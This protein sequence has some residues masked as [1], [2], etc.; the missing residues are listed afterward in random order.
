MQKANLRFGFYIVET[1]MLRLKIR[2]SL[3]KNMLA[4]KVL[5]QLLKHKQ[6]YFYLN[7]AGKCASEL[8]T[9]DIQSR[10]TCD[11]SCRIWGNTW[12]LSF[13]VEENSGNLQLAGFIIM[14]HP[15]DVWL[16][17]LSVFTEPRN[18]QIW[19]HSVHLQSGSSGPHWD[20]WVLWCH[21]CKLY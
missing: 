10:S 8:L 21:Y 18:L 20:L 4:E 1:N 6:G 5:V 3:V 12:V 14:R 19:R 7:V 2:A 9:V 15:E 17:D 16:S 13:V 11:H